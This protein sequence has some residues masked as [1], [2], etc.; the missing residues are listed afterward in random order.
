MKSRMSF[1]L[2]RSALLFALLLLS[3]AVHAENGCPSGQ[4]PHAGSDLSS[5]GPVPAGYYGNQQRAP[6]QQRQ[7]P[8]PLWA[9]RWGAIATDNPHGGAGAAVNQPNR[10]M[11][12][13]SAMAQCRSTG[14]SACT[15]DIAY[16]DKCVALVAGDSKYAVTTRPT[17]HEATQSGMDNCRSFGSTDCNV[18]YSACSLP[19][20]IR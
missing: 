17:L 18:E 7:S 11:A 9:P 6:A 8:S 12:E 2:Q 10:A 16:E 1:F 14:G 19:M 4:I 15:I 5:C 3:A 20:R 13:Q